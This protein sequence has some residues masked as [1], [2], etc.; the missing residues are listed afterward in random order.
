LARLRGHADRRLLRPDDDFL[1]AGLGVG[2]VAPDDDRAS[3]AVAL[4]ALR[5]ESQRAL[6][7]VSER[8]SE[9][10]MFGSLVRQA[11]T[12]TRSEISRENR[13]FVCVCQLRRS[14]KPRRATAE[15]TA[16]A[17]RASRMGW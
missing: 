9:W 14:R 13:V 3:S 7:R 5:T 1:G 11:T 17:A 16:P 12:R 6:E 2:L 8:L 15:A 10:M 4:T